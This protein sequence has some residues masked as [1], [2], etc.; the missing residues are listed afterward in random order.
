MHLIGLALAHLD[1][2]VS[3]DLAFVLLREPYE[4][5]LYLSL[6]YYPSGLH[7]ALAHLRPRVLAVESYRTL[8]RLLTDRATAKFLHHRSSID[9]RMIA[10]LASLPPEL[11]CPPIL[12]MFGKIDGMDRFVDGLKCIAARAGLT[13][14]ALAREIGGLAQTEQVVAKIKRLTESLPVLHTL[15]PPKVGPY[16]RLDNVAEIRALAKDWQNCLGACIA[17]ITDGTSA[18]YATDL[19]HA[20]AAAFVY[21]QWRLGWFLEQAKGPRNI[22]LA[23]Q[24]LAQTYSDF[25]GAGILQASTIESI[26]SMIMTDEW[27]RLYHH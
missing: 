6:G 23:P 24:Q 17:T 8:A 13:F 4:K 15:P 5:I 1:G 10:G 21:R 27:S 7:R 25:A 12:G 11:R 16:R 26:K 2:E 19:P 18:I 9:E 22:D 14:E 3:P 20:P